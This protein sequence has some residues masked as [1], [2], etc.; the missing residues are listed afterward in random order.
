MVNY[1]IV[2]HKPRNATCRRFIVN[3]W[4][5]KL[6]KYFTEKLGSIIVYPLLYEK[7]IVLL[8][9]IAKNFFFRGKGE[10]LRKEMKKKE[11]ERI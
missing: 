7:E 8:Q 10:V 9:M 3:T 6:R 5:E 11:R 4:Q 2:Q 1:D